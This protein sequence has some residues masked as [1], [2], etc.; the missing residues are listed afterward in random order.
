MKFL[1]NKTNRNSRCQFWSTAKNSP[2]YQK[3]F[4]SS[5]R[6]VL[7]VSTSEVWSRET[8]YE[9]LV[10]TVSSS[11]WCWFGMIVA[12]KWFESVWTRHLWHRDLGHTTLRAEFNSMFKVLELLTA[13]F[14]F[15]SSF[16]QSNMSR[17][18]LMKHKRKRQKS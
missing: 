7:A 6:F 5:Q 10:V 15:K 17:S 11:F 1:T 4:R 2:K 16:G 8:W 9:S 13:C 18:P 12:K 14:Y 3:Y